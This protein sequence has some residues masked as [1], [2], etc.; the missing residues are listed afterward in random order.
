MPV[1]M[2]C[3]KILNFVIAHVAGAMNKAIEVKIQST[4]VPEEE[5]LYILPEETPTEQQ[6]WEEK[7]TLRKAAEMGTHNDSENEGS[8]LQ[9]FHKPIAGIYDYKAGH[10]KD[11]AKVHLEQNNDQVLRNFLNQNRRLI[12]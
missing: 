11:N 1:T 10:F 5:P 6:L 7:E 9:N 4:G 3:S 12:L 8:E 2:Y